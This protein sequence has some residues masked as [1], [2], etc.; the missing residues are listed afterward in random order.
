MGYL[1]FNIKL[2]SAATI[3]LSY[4]INYYVGD[5]LYQALLYSNNQPA[6]QIPYST[7]INGVNVYVD[8]AAETIFVVNLD[9][10]CLNFETYTINQN[11]I[12]LENGITFLGTENGNN[13]E[14]E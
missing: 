8:D 6:T 10:T 12:L 11:L 1:Y 3:G 7:L 14:K 9:P 5:N 13:L 4:D 2:D